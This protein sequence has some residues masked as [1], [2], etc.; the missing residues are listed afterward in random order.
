MLR[1]ALRRRK[2]C[3]APPVQKRRSKAPGNTVGEDVRERILQGAARAFGKLGYASTRVEDVLRAAEVSRPTF[4]KAFG[5]KDD[6]FDA[7]SERHHGDI[8]ER[9]VQCIGGVTEPAAQLEATVLTFM[10][11]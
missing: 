4:Y 3:D 8:R 1:A 5:G 2:P 7:L 11:W 9:I 6:V 10:R